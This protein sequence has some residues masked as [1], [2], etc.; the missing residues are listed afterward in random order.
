M[1]D[2]YVRTAAG[3]VFLA[4]MVA[5]CFAGSPVLDIL[6]GL[7]VIIGSAEFHKMT[8]LPLPSWLYSTLLLG[9]YLLLAKSFPVAPLASMGG[10]MLLLLLLFLISRTHSALALLGMLFTAIP[11]GLL[12]QLPWL[13]GHFPAILFFFI[14]LWTNDTMAY[15]TG[16]LFGRRKLAPRIS[17]KKTWEGFAGGVLFAM[18]IG[19]FLAPYIYSP[20]WKGVAAGTL[21]GILGTVGDLTE[22]RLKRHF[23]I[24]DSGQLIPGHGGVLDR[25]D[26]LLYAAPVFVLLMDIEATL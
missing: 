20:T 1:K 4:I 13:K 21:I 3:A 16:R 2:V 10:L 6:F 9:I 22:S 8:K 19:Y 12:L 25:F 18:I 24:K 14:L 23:E 11:F 15:V 7:L 17:P 26:G 5:A